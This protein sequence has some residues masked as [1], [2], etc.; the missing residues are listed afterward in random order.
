MLS[1]THLIGRLPAG[2]ATAQGSSVTAAETSSHHAS[3]ATAAA[4]PSIDF[5]YLAG[6]A[7]RRV[8]ESTYSVWA[9]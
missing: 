4:D 2:I 5:V 3:S 1:N 7:A 8:T 6:D 9:A